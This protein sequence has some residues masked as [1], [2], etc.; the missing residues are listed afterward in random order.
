MDS[1]TLQKPAAKPGKKA[2]APGGRTP[3]RPTTSQELKLFRNGS[4]CG[5]GLG[6]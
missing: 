6:V 5:A 2:R 4:F 3:T 1:M